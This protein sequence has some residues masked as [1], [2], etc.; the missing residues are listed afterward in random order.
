MNFVPDFKGA[1]LIH[2]GISNLGKLHKR[3]REKVLICCLTFR[4]QAPL[5]L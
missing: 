4:I 2:S 1:M 5:F 3:V